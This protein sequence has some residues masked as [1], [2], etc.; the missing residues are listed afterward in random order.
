MA[1]LDCKQTQ[2]GLALLS[3]GEEAAKR[4]NESI[5]K[6]LAG[7]AGNVYDKE[8]AGVGRHV[9]DVGHITSVDLTDAKRPCRA[10]KKDLPQA[11]TRWQTARRD[12]DDCKK[13]SKRHTTPG[14]LHKLNSPPPLGPS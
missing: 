1:S 5:E 14:F 2:G 3:C 7:L 9:G 4:E 10:G 13:F 6:H 8:K 12:R 11:D